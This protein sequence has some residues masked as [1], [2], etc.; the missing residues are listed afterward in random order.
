LA[1]HLEMIRRLEGADASDGEIW[2]ALD[3]LLQGTYSTKD[4][5][6]VHHAVQSRGNA[7]AKP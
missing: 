3:R 6:D 1:E 2:P 7:P 5:R 4:E